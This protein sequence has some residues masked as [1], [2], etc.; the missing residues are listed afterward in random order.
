[1]NIH[2]DSFKWIIESEVNSLC[3]RL[4][5]DHNFFFTS[6]W[7]DKEFNN[8]YTSRFLRRLKDRWCD[9]ERLHVYGG[10]GYG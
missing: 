4:P 6:R 9:V 2:T 5:S 10:A 3:L 7:H 1:M 8:Y